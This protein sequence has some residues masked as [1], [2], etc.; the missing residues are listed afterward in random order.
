[1]GWFLWLLQLPIIFKE[2]VMNLKDKSLVEKIFT[3]T[4]KSVLAWTHKIETGTM[5]TTR[6]FIF[7]STICFP[8]KFEFGNWKVKLKGVRI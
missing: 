7:D 1:M 4:N 8:I 5:L 3:P 2:D 6:S